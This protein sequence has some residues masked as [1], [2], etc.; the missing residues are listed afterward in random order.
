MRLKLLY[1]GFETCFGP[2]TQ[3]AGTKTHVESRF[4]AILFYIIFCSTGQPLVLVLARTHACVVVQRL[5]G[6]ATL[7]VAVQ[8]CSYVWCCVQRAACGVLYTARSSSPSPSLAISH[9]VC[10]CV[11]VRSC[12]CVFV[13]PCD[14]RENC[15]CVVLMW[16]GWHGRYGII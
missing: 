16:R 9:P 10:A 4:C 13:C 11:P 15:L 2:S 1:A 12:V 5:C 14:A 3:D 8:R 7:C 6:G